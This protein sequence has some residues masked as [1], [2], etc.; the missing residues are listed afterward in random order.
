MVM[1]SS[2][3]ITLQ[4]IRNQWQAALAGYYGGSTA[5]MT[6]YG[7]ALPAYNL[8]AYRGTNYFYEIDATDTGYATFPSGTITLE[9]FYGKSPFPEWNCNCACSDCVCANC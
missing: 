3:T 6:S 8:L 7:V 1:Q 2:G 9:T 4:Q 5:Q